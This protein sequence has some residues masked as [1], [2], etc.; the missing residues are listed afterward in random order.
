MEVCFNLRWNTVGGE[1]WSETNTNVLCND[2][3]YDISGKYIIL[4]V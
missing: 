3:G 2:L 1:E 4:A